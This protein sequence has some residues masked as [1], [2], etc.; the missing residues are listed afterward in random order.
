MD[1]VLTGTTTPG[2]SGPKSNDNEVLVIHQTSEQEPHQQMQFN[3]I[4]RTPIFRREFCSF[5]SC[6]F[7]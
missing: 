4:S 3:V 1:G 5:M 2:Q 7:H 6:V